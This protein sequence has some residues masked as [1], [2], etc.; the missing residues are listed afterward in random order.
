MLYTPSIDLLIRLSLVRAQLGEPYSK[1]LYLRKYGAFL[2]TLE[3]LPETTV[4]VRSCDAPN[5][6]S[7]ANG[8]TIRVGYFS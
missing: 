5:P 1:A 8:V 4:C 3:S 6:L 7:T 2:F